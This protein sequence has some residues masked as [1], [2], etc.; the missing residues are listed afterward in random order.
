[1]TLN[2][3][4]VKPGETILIPFNAFDSND[5]SASVIV[6]DFVLADIGIYKATSMTER[7]STTGVVLLDTDGINIDGATGIHGFSIDLS[8]NA[9]DDFYTAGS[10]YYVT[11]GPI[12]IDGAAVSFVAATFEIGYPGAILNAQI[13]TLASQTSFTITNAPTDDSALVGCTVII[14]DQ[15]SATQFAVGYVSAYTTAAN[16][17]TLKAD[18]GIFTMAAGDNVSFF[19]P[20]NVQAIAGTTQTAG[21]LAAAVITNAAGTDIA[22]DII[23]L[24]A[25]TVLILADVTGINGADLDSLVNAFVLTTAIIETVTSQSQLVIPATADAVADGA[26][27]GALA[28]LI[29]D[30][31]ANN[32]SIRIIE[33]YD[34]GTRTVTLSKDPD[35]TVTTSDRIT[36]LATSD[37]GGVWDMLLTG[38]K[39][40]LAT[41]AGKRLRQLEEAFVL[42]EG[43]IAT[44][45]DGRT[46]TL[47]TGA[48]A[49]ADFYIGARLQIEEGT[50]AGQTR[51][52]VAYSVG[53]VVLLDSVWTTNP[54]T[55]SRYSIVASDVHVSVS[56]SD[57]A[58]GLVATATSTTQITLDSGALANADYYNEALIIFT[59]GTGAGQF[60]HITAYTAGRVAT[61][62]PALDTA[63]GTD[64]VYHIQS[65]VP[66]AQIVN[67]LLDRAL[68]GHIVA[69]SV[70]LVLGRLGRSVGVV[71]EY[72]IDNTSF[73]AT[74]I[75]AQVDAVDI[76]SL[77]ATDDH[78][79]GRIMIFTSG[80]NKHQATDITDYDGTN[81]RF[82]YTAVTDIPADDDTFIVV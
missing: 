80:A 54:D 71:Q 79:I 6:S 69:D 29:D 34:A 22:A 55:A 38:S 13:A 48:V 65:V 28:I 62:S 10:R 66:I 30:G 5:P 56:D 57:L 2:L 35:F 64:T 24:K 15:A 77:E 1:M 51:I 7:G 39:H 20:A 45:T 81:K 43:V 78:F 61:L 53:R 21:D 33:A 70:G 25:E 46:L 14:H 82:S 58:E 76:D 26:Y 42:A 74:T 41:S 52:I 50:G 60:S 12:T 18:P 63:V 75:A 3:G 23:A 4:I 16:T 49:T 31:D 72:T 47:D 73:T 44:Q 11:V 32:K 67:E 8:S 68:A 37:A 36:I 19:M 59:H 27:H 9:T 17:I 40:N